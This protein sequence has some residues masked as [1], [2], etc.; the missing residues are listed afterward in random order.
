MAIGDEALR[1]P[2]PQTERRL[3]PLARRRFKTRRPLR[4][5]IRSKNPWVR[6]RRKLLG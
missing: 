5:L 1:L 3:R 6:A 4:V 2:T